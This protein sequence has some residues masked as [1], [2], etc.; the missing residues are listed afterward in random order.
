MGCL[1]Q[2]HITGWWQNEDPTQVSGL[3]MQEY[4][5]DMEMLT[6][7]GHTTCLL[8]NSPETPFHF[9][10]PFEGGSSSNSS[11]PLRIYHE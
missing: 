9:Y 5:N 4:K 11:S 8:T 7:Q 1:A 2:G 6:T 10:D 3:L